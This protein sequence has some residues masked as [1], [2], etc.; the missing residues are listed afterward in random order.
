MTERERLIKLLEGKSI[1]TMADVEYVADYLLENGVIVP[2]VK[3][4]QKVYYVIESLGEVAEGCIREIIVAEEV[5]V[6]FTLKGWFSQTSH[7]GEIGKTVFLTKE[8][9]LQAL[10]GA[11]GK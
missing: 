9:A 1:D 7:I 11:E 4:G 3:V 10:K 6:N 8:E 2:P 5:F